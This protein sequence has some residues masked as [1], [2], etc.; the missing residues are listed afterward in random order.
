MFTNE[1]NGVIRAW[2]AAALGGLVVKG[3]LTPDA[4][5]QIITGVLGIVGVIGI[6]FWSWFSNNLTSLLKQ[7]AEYPEVSKIVAWD[8]VANAVPSEKVVPSDPVRDL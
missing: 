3:V 6:S 5:E 7:A 4:A 2:L 1:I 8:P